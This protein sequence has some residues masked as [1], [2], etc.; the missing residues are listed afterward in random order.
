MAEQ[1][2]KKGVLMHFKPTY[3]FQ[4]IE[5]DYEYTPENEQEILDLLDK[6][7]MMMMAT[8]PMQPDTQ[9]KAAKKAYE[10]KAT[11]KQLN[12]LRNLGVKVSGD[13]TAAEAS[14]MIKEAKEQEEMEF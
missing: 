4:T 10:P 12:Y 1:K 9:K 11:I 6:C 5:F 7:Y 8:A 13:I 2:Q 3:D 14:R